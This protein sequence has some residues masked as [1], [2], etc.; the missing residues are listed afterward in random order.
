ML[1]VSLIVYPATEDG[2]FL[3]GFHTRGKHLFIEPLAGPPV[4][5]D[6]MS[7]AAKARDARIVAVLVEYLG[8]A[9]LSAEASAG[10]ETGLS[11]TLLA[12]WAALVG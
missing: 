3:L 5:P 4:R 7:Y 1:R 10:I 12:D 9:V 2:L 11:Y 6:R 8:I